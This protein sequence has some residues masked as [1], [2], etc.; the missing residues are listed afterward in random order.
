MGEKKYKV[1]SRGILGTF[2]VGISIFLLF[3]AIFTG[4]WYSF[5]VIEGDNWEYPDKAEED[6]DLDEMVIEI[7]KYH[8]DDE[9]IVKTYELEGKKNDVCRNTLTI[10][11]LGLVLMFAF[12]VIGVLSSLRL[13]RGR[14][15]SIAG[16]MVIS[17]L[18]ISLIYYPTAYPSA[19]RKDYFSETWDLYDEYPDELREELLDSGKLGTS[20]FMVCISFVLLAIAIA[21]FWG[22]PKRKTNCNNGP[23]ESESVHRGNR[24]SDEI[25][26][27]P[28]NHDNR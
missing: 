18:L 15:T 6:H 23:V 7:D 17:L 2:L 10:L 20:Y 9:E 21:L 13:F 1:S 3:L 28:K 14:M 16:M 24:I 22:I 11:I 25:V 12:L 5:G 19:A 26:H 8:W 27:H 4:T